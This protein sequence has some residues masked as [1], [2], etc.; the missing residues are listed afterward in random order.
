MVQQQWAVA[1]PLDFTRGVQDQSCLECSQVLSLNSVAPVIPM[2]PNPAR[3]CRHT[4][5][6]RGHAAWGCCGWQEPEAAAVMGEGDPWGSHGPGGVR[7]IEAWSPWEWDTGM[8]E[9][10]GMEGLD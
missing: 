2:C 6:Q 10:G 3:H 8:S 7:H 1:K 5:S 9:K 4:R